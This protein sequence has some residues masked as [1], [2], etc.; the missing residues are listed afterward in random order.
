MPYSDAILFGILIQ[1]ST[2]AAAKEASKVAVGALK[3]T[4]EGLRPEE[5][6]SAVAKARFA[7]ANAIESRE[8]LANVLAS[9]V[10]SPKS[11]FLS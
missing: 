5:F 9:K 6:S 11:A 3:S 10:C 8:G 7:A 4:S 2:V 1:G